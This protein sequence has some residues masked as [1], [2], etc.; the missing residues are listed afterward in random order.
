MHC[1]LSSEKTILLDKLIRST[2]TELITMEVDSLVQIYLAPSDLSQ[3]TIIKLDPSF[4]ETFE[5]STYKLVSFP[6]IA[7]HES[8]MK[9]LDF[10]L[11]EHR[12]I[13]EYH[14]DKMKHIKTF[15]SLEAEI[16]DIEFRGE[17]GVEVDLPGLKR[18]LK[19]LKG[20][21]LRI[22]MGEYLRILGHDVEI[23]MPQASME[24]EFSINT[25]KFK[26]LVLISNNFYATKFGFSA[27][28]SP[29][30]ITME[31]PDVSLSTFISIE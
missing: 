9:S 3:L 13:L 31:G 8:N 21:N 7:F 5:N 12:V 19:E 4:F 11:E 24:A 23:S 25:E 1:S 18:V 26:L 15:D 10:Q 2:K 20:K 28:L 16:F 14:F 27:D 6:V 17:R 22:R 30:N 29:L